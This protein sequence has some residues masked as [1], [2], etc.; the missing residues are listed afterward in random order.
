MGDERQVKW[1]KKSGRKR[2]THDVAQDFW[3]FLEIRKEERK[4]KVSLFSKWR[5]G[6]E[7]KTILL[8][9]RVVVVVVVVIFIIVVIVVIVV[10]AVVVVVVVVVVAAVIFDDDDDDVGAKAKKRLTSL[11]RAW[12]QHQSRSG[13]WHL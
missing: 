1:Q 12:K 6:R 10:V 7:E 4:K 5:I 9:Y 2:E 13:H 3:K 11:R 8:I